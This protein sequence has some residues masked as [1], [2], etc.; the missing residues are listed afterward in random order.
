[1][2]AFKNLKVDTALLAKVDD[3]KNQVDA[4]KPLPKDVEGKIWQKFRLDWNYHSNAIEGNSLT[5]GETLVFLREGLTAK[6]KPLKDHLDMKGH[7][8]VIEYLFDLIKNKDYELSEHDIRNLH[9]MLLVEPYESK[10]QTADG[11]PTTKTITLGEYKKLPNHVKT[12]TGDIHYYASPEETPARMTDLIDWYRREKVNLHPV[13]LAA[14]LH[15]EFVNIHPFDDGNGRMSRILM[16]LI[17]L[18]NGYPPVVIKQGNRNEY[19]TALAQADA[20]NYEPFIELIATNLIH[21]LEIYIKGAKGED[22]TEPDDVDKEIELLKVQLKSKEDFSEVSDTMLN[23][24]VIKI[25]DFAIELS[26]KGQKL[27]ELFFEKSKLNLIGFDTSSHRSVVLF[28]SPNLLNVRFHLL[29]TKMAIQEFHG[30]LN[31]MIL[32]YEWKHFKKSNKFFNIEKQIRFDLGVKHYTVS[33]INGF[34]LQKNYSDFLSIS[35]KKNLIEIIIKSV[36]EDIKKIS[37]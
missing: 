4:L 33:S 18:Q 37:D 27:D 23:D 24:L 22:I 2:L 12:P 25:N 29:S 19:Y 9:T 1:M 26:E 13:V 10:A 7:N 16:N 3:L 21:S 8:E 31:Q 35:E 32:F 14:L 30:K 20:K 11:L 17:L 15:Y 5:F 6:G 36:I 34:Q 28:D